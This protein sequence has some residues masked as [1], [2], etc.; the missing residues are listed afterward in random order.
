M[1]IIDIE[2]VSKFVKEYGV[3]IIVDNIFMLLYL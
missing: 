3:F 2:E 1:D